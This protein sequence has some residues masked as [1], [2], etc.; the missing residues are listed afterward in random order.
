MV[1]KDNNW[2]EDSDVL[3]IVPTFG[4]MIQ[5]TSEFRDS[6]QTR[7]LNF[8]NRM[9]P[10]LAEFSLVNRQSNYQLYK[11]EPQLGEKL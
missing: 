9:N 2:I 6:V 3:S 7:I 5:S 1:S 4:W 10:V 11:D 8:L